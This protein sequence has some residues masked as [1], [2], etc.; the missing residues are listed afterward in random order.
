MTTFSR[1]DHAPVRRVVI[2]HTLDGK[3][4]ELHLFGTK[5]SSDIFW[6]DTFPSD[7]G[8]E[9]T[10]PVK[11]HPQDSTSPNGSSFRVMDILFYRDKHR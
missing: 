3:A 4:I 6:T 9:F 11:E 2:G 8:V 10:D 7:N 5:V 1:P